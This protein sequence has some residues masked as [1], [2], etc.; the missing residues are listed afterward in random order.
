MTTLEVLSALASIATAGGVG[1]AAW[2]LF[3]TRQQ[4]VTSFED[5]LTSQYRALIERIPVEA[6]F[7]EKLRPGDQAALLRISI[8]TLI[9]VTSRLSCVSWDESQRR[10]GSTGRTAS[11]PIWLGPHLLPRGPRSHTGRGET[12]NTFAHSARRLCRVSVE[13]APNRVMLKTERLR[14]RYFR[15]KPTTT[16]KISRNFLGRIVG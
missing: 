14:H 9:S 12:S 10:R 4:A 5:S 8:A 1:V 6:L 3:V 11:R 15:N 7:G 2:Q 13:A 16:P